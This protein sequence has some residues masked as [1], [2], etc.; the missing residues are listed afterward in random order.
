MKSKRI[1]SML[2]AGAAA[3]LTLALLSG[4]VAAKPSDGTR[5]FDGTVASIAKN[6]GALTIN[7]AGGSQTR[8]VVRSSTTYEHIS[9]LSDLSRGT[10]VEVH[11]FRRVT[12]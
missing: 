11:A 1:A 7:Q 4:P 5:S 10:P 12:V 2:L 6:G 3:I 9:G 8:F